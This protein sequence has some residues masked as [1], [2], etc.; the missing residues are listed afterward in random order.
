[1]RDLAIMGGRRLIARNSSVNDNSSLVVV[2]EAKSRPLVGTLVRSVYDD[3]HVLAQRYGSAYNTKY[4]QGLQP[5]LFGVPAH[6][7]IKHLEVLWPGGEREVIPV[8]AGMSKL[9]LSQ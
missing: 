2:L 6:A 4:S 3:G 1:M 5:L 7:K 9:T 8:E